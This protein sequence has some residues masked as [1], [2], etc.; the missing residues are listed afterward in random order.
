MSSTSTPDERKLIWFFIRVRGRR[1]SAVYRECVDT[2]AIHCV[3]NPTDCRNLDLIRKDHDRVRLITVKGE[4][5]ALV[6][7]ALSMK[8][9]NTDLEVSNTMI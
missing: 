9:E 5:M 2:G 1:G 3:L 8:I 7:V 6:Y 4:T